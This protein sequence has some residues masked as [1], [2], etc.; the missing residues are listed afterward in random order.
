MCLT[1]HWCWWCPAATH[2]SAA[3]ATPVARCGGGRRT[4]VLD[5]AICEKARTTCRCANWPSYRPCATCGPVAYPAERAV[6]GF[7]AGGQRR[8]C[9]TGHSSEAAAPANA[10]HSGLSGGHGG[11][12]RPTAAALCSWRRR[13]AAQ[14]VFGLEDKITQT[15]PVL[16]TT[17]GCHRSMENTLMLVNA[18]H[19]VGVHARRICLK[20]GCTV[21]AS[22][23]QRWISPATGITGRNC[24]GMKL[25]DTFAFSV[26]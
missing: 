24:G 1:G 8:R 2:V 9:C 3:R 16:W 18:L 7:S 12:Y 17:I 15:P 6:C 14:Q 25:E 23:Q 21:P 10:G 26:C 5:C 20:R 13:P 19:R 11:R 22:A 4:A